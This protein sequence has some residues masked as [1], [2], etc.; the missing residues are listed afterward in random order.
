MA[1]LAPILT[2]TG[3]GVVIPGDDIDTDRII[4]ARYLRCVTF[5]DL[6]EGLF[7]DERDRAQR[8]RGERALAEGPVG[9]HPLDRSEHEGARV[10]VSGRNFGCGSSR[11][12]APQAIVRAGFRAVIAGSFAEIFFG[13]ATTLGLVCLALDDVALAAVQARVRDEAATEL[14]IDVRAASVTLDGQTY[15]GRMPAAART[16]LASG[17]YDP[18][19]ELLAADDAIAAVA[20]RLPYVHAPAG[21]R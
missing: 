18:L 7:R 10:L 19:A 12:H 8:V 1:T 9:P 4:P 6:A 20:A 5:D 15:Q 21:R 11:E 2:V 3:R 14:V 13:N 16:A 17:R